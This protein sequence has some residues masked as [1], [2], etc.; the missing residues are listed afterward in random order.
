MQSFLISV[1]AQVVG[2]IILAALLYGIKVLRKHEE[3][4]PGR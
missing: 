2:G 4:H 1:A 3:D